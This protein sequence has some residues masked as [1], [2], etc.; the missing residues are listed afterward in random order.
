MSCFVIDAG[1]T[2]IRL[3]SGQAL[4]LHLDYFGARKAKIFLKRGSPVNG[5]CLIWEIQVSCSSSIRIF[6]LA[7]RTRT[8]L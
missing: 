5:C 4:P 3:R 6:S 1:G 7:G 2:P 8:G